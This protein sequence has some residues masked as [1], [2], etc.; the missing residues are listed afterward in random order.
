MSLALFS[1]GEPS[2]SEVK[3][4]SP[5]KLMPKRIYTASPDRTVIPE[6]R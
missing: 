5:K 3:K 1:L 4:E 6:A 2:I